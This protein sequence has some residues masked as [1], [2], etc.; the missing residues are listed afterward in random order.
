MHQVKRPFLV[1]AII[2]AT[3][4]IGQ[5]S[6]TIYTPA[7]PA[8]AIDFAVSKGEAQY[9]L[10]S[11]LLG[12]GLLQLLYGPISDYK[13]RRIISLLGLVLAIFGS[14]LSAQALNIHLLNIGVFV[15]GAG[16]GSAGV[17][18]KA[19]LR[20]L[21]RGPELQIAMSL[22]GASL[23]V[24]PLVAPY[25][26]SYLVTHFGWRSNFVFLI[27]TSL[28][29]FGLAYFLLE[30]TNSY[31]YVEHKAHAGLSIIAVFQAVLFD[32]YYVLRN[33]VFLG[34]MLCGLF[35][36]ICLASYEVNTPFIFREE[37][38]MT[39]LEYGKSMIVPASGF[40]IGAVLASKLS[41]K[42]NANWVTIMGVTINWL[43]SLVMLYFALIHEFSL[44]IALWPMFFYL[45]GSAL[46]Y[47]SANTEALMPFSQ[48][49]GIAA[50]SMGF[51]QNLGTALV[52]AILCWM[53][54]SNQ[55]EM[56][57]V[58][59]VCSS[60]SALV[61]ILIIL[62]AWLKSGELNKVHI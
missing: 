61:F 27:G 20:D 10:S 46:L 33:K 51:L 26:G 13:G 43:S 53:C 50:A 14:L 39:Y 59:T 47:A 57:L 42:V 44:H 45:I 34:N 29:L 22:V 60:L 3:Y 49:A 12:F 21:F 9:L 36:F 37:F 17:M 8:I 2:I 31:V 40:L 18:S 16:I 7:L 56:A 38:G 58:F 48:R 41:R 1:T 11:F 30:E 4:A 54:M 5:V 35:N 32:F 24:V 15:I 19:V 23:V 25:I 6:E 28:V 62:P 52:I 55:Y